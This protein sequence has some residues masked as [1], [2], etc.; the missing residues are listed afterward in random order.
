VIL[1][2][3]LVNNRVYNLVK[4][5]GGVI[6]EK[7]FIKNIEF[8]KVLNLAD[9]V[10]YKPGQVISQTLVQTPNFSITLFALSAG[11]GISTHTTTGD[12]MVYI[13]DGEAEITIGDKTVTPAAGQTVIMPANIPH[14]LEARKSFKMLLIIVK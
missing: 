8:S 3:E 4:K 5:D 1:I 6:M 7:N 14:G 12:A 13:L 9:L 11:E 2:T 10:E